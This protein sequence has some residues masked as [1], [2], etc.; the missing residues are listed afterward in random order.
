MARH[1]MLVPTE[2]AEVHAEAARLFI[3][4][5]LVTRTDLPDTQISSC[6]IGRPQGSPVA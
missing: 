2:Q 1:P 6:Y 4:A 5:E 3:M